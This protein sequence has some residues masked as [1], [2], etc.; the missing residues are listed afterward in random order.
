MTPF[1][2]AAGRSTQP[3]RVKW[4]RHSSA[5]FL[6]RQFFKGMRVKAE[7]VTGPEGE[8]VLSRNGFRGEVERMGMWAFC[9]PARKV[10]VVHYW[11]ARTAD[12]LHLAFLLGHELGHASGKRLNSLRNTWREEMRADEYGACAAAVLKEIGRRK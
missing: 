9:I 11:A 8:P 4:V 7:D 6:V 12:R 5:T 3:K 1:A 2:K 10:P